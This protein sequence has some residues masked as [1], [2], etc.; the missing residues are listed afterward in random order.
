MAPRSSTI[1]ASKVGPAYR[2]LLRHFAFY[3]EYHNDP[4]NQ[5]IHIGK[6]Q[7][8]EQRGFP[9]TFIVG[10]PLSRTVSITLHSSSG[11]P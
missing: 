2:N 4:V 8:Q 7:S 9:D 6:H 1:D 3:A 11:I 10:L 5:W